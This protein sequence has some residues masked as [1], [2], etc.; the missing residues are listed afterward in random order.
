MTAKISE[1]TEWVDIAKA[2]SILLV[3]FHH[4]IFA[5]SPLTGQLDVTF[6]YFRMPVFFFASGMFIAKMMKLEAPAFIANRLLPLLYIFVVWS[7]IKW[8]FIDLFR[9]LFI[10]GE[11]DVSPLLNIFVDPPQTLW[12]IYALAIFSVLSWLGRKLPRSV[13]TAIAVVIALVPIVAGSIADGLFVTKLAKFFVWFWLGYVLSDA[14]KTW[15]QQPI[16]PLTF[17][18]VPI[19]IAVSFIV[20][21]SGESVRFWSLPLTI[22]ALPVGFVIAVSLSRIRVGTPLAWLGKNTL[23]IYVTHFVALSLMGKVFERLHL[24]RSVLATIITAAIAVVF[25]LTVKKLADR[26][27]FAWLYEMPLGWRRRIEVA[28]IRARGRFDE[29]AHGEPSAP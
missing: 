10:R 29:R 15:A 19:W 22:T 8:A 3:V 17:L 16:H 9:Y 25:A 20:L 4:A 7:I 1:R 18:I 14:A 23:P 26:F 13:V 21:N 28:L 24:P 27:W 12:F 6:T 2:L 11:L 5:W